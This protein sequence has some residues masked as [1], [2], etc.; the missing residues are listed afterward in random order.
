MVRYIVSF[1][2]I[3]LL[4][5]TLAYADEEEFN[6][7]IKRVTG[8]KATFIDKDNNEVTFEFAEPREED[9]ITIE[10]N[11]KYL[12]G[13]NYGPYVVR[14]KMQEND[15]YKFLKAGKVTA[16]DA[17]IIVVKA[18]IDI[19]RQNRSKPLYDIS[20][21]GYSYDKTNTPPLS[22]SDVLIK[23]K[24]YE[25]LGR[26]KYIEEVA[27]TSYYAF[28][29]RALKKAQHIIDISLSNVIDSDFDGE[30]VEL[31]KENIL[32]LALSEF[33]M[34]GFYN[35]KYIIEQITRLEEDGQINLS[36]LLDFLQYFE[37]A[38]LYPK[39]TD[40]LLHIITIGQEYDTVQEFVNALK[41]GVEYKISFDYIAFT[42]G[43]FDIYND[44]VYEMV[45]IDKFNEYSILNILEL[46]PDSKYS[47]LYP[48]LYKL[49]NEPSSKSD[50]LD[51]KPL[52]CTDNV[53]TGNLHIL[54]YNGVV[55]ILNTSRV[56]D[57]IV[58]IEARTPAFFNTDY[59]NNYTIDPLIN[60]AGGDTQ[61]LNKN[62]VLHQVS[63]MGTFSYGNKSQMNGIIYENKITKEPMSPLGDVGK[64]TDMRGEKIM[65]QDM[66][67][68]YNISK[69]DKKNDEKT[70]EALV[71]Y[72][73]YLR[74]IAD[75]SFSETSELYF[76][77]ISIKEDEPVFL[78]A[79][80][81][82][83]NHIEYLFP[84]VGK[85]LKIIDKKL[86]E[87]LMDSLGGK[88]K[89]AIVNKTDNGI[90]IGYIRSDNNIFVV[91]IVDGK[92]GYNSFPI[93]DYK[94]EKK[95]ENYFIEDYLL[96]SNEKLEQK[97]GIACDSDLYSNSL[98]CS[99]RSLLSAVAYIKALY[100]R[101]VETT[102][103]MSYPIYIYDYLEDI[104]A[105]FGSILDNKCS[106][107]NSYDEC[108]EAILSYEN[109]F[110]Y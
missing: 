23:G 31:Y 68:R 29:N 9:Y 46:V 57:K 92:A 44:G 34:S 86:V 77:D 18:L 79:L 90:Y 63:N 10:D 88:Y 8:G 97:A 103:T 109:V 47:N 56:D 55:Y 20:K 6:I 37:L 95:T 94:D 12:N 81:C 54:P 67:A 51:Y 76:Y 41:L 36:S 4:C 14:G 21:M 33:A 89:Q 13:L 30:L 39:E 91:N 24:I 98:I 16:D 62:L 52:H 106:N 53:Y 80:Y 73:Y 82:D 22:C 85:N 2:L 38:T 7:S 69:F 83:V 102:S 17:K 70:K 87:P 99:D 26:D 108:M 71:D 32:F 11:N 104:Y 75:E 48:R 3:T 28:R 27:N 64:I 61:A 72:I 93:Y 101:K 96:E 84:V 35:N 19:F 49:I 43:Y 78:A 65:P 25:E 42:K 59:G 66:K 110:K 107:K 100:E 105:N 5:S 74:E 45:Q 1:L 58:K 15:Y 40:L 60:K 50:T